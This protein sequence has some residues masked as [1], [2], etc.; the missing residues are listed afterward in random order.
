MLGVR[1]TL[2]RERLDLLEFPEMTVNPARPAPLG[3]TALPALPAFRAQTA[4]QARLE[5]LVS[6]ER[7][8]LPARLVLQALPELTA[9]GANQAL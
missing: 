3:R 7:P 5:P 2:Q 6:P 8:E 9:P 4:S 1:L